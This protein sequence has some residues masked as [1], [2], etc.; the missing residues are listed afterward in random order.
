MKRKFVTASILVAA[1]SV[2][3]PLVAFAKDMTTA[4]IVI[5]EKGFSLKQKA[6]VVDIAKAIRSGK[7]ERISKYTK[8]EEDPNAIYRFWSGIGELSKIRFRA[9]IVN[10]TFI[11]SDADRGMATCNITKEANNFVVDE[12]TFNDGN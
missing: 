8:S 6:A 9:R 11:L 12:C 7:V 1:L 5:F 10:S 3:F 4:G 2:I